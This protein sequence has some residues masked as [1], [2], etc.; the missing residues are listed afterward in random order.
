MN[1]ITIEHK[2]GAITLNADRVDSLHKSNERYHV[3]VENPQCSYS[4]LELNK[5]QYDKLLKYFV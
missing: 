5:D 2:D 3:V 4:Y 1:F